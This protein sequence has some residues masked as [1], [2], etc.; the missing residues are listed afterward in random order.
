MI[1]FAPYRTLQHVF[2]DKKYWLSGFFVVIFFIASWGQSPFTNYTLLTEKDG[3]PSYQSNCVLEDMDGYLW[4]GLHHGLLRYDGR[5]F[6]KIGDAKSPRGQRI[7][8]LAVAD[9]L[10]VLVGTDVGVSKVNIRTFE[11]NH[12]YLPGA[13]E[14]SSRIN[15]V[16]QIQKS[17]HGNFWLVST[18]GVFLVSGALVVLQ[19]YYFPEELVYRA[20]HLQSSRIWEMA[21]GKVWVTAPSGK[22]DEFNTPG[23]IFE[24]D[25]SAKTMQ[26]IQPQ[27]FAAAQ[28]FVTLVHVNDTL[29]LF[30][31]KDSEG[32]KNGIFDLRTRTHRLIDIRPFVLENYIPFFSRIQL[33]K[34]G[35]STLKLSHYYVFDVTSCTWEYWPVQPQTLLTSVVRTQSGIYFSATPWGLMVTASEGNMFRVITPMETFL[36]HSKE[37]PV[38]SSGHVRSTHYEAV[39]CRGGRI[40]LHSHQDSVQVLRLPYPDRRFAD[41]N[42]R[43]VVYGAADTVL[44]GTRFGVQWWHPPSGATGHL[45]G[46]K[47][48]PSID[49]LTV[50]LFKDHIGDIW[51]G[52]THS[53]GLLRFDVKDRVFKH[54]PFNGKYGHIQL[55]EIEAFAEDKAG[56]LWMGSRYGGGLLKWVRGADSLIVHHPGRKPGANFRDYITGLVCDHSG[57]IWIGT[58]GYGVFVFHPDEMIFKQYTSADGLISDYVNTITIDCQGYVWI[59]ANG[60]SRLDA[61]TG[62]VKRF[63][64]IHGLPSLN[65]TKLQTD[66]QDSCVLFI[67]TDAGFRQI[68]VLELEEP[69]EDKQIIIN[70]ILVNGSHFSFIPGNSFR[71]TYDENNLEIEFSHLN[72]LDGRQDQYFYRMSNK[73]HWV[74]LGNS[75]EVHLTGLRSGNYNLYLKVCSSGG[76]CFEREMLSFSI[77]PPF[78]KTPWYYI[79]LCCFIFGGIVFYYRQRLS[80]LQGLIQLRRKISYDLHDDIGSNLGSIRILT[81]L[82]QNPQVSSEK[83]IEVADKIREITESAHRNLEE[84]IWELRPGNEQMERVKGRLLQIAT[85]VL[86]PHGIEVRFLAQEDID[87]L[88]LPSEKQRNLLLL[89]REA[90]NNIIKHAYCRQVWI[91]INCRN[92]MLHLEII[93]DGVGFDLDISTHKRGNGMDTL[94][95]RAQQLGGTLEIESE[96]GQGV[97]L[98]LQFAL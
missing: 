56:N 97:R 10:H 76:R 38:Y 83:K 12:L 85:E 25:P 31:F 11:E 69:D 87:D 40:V 14:L 9:S 55:R 19:S 4:V 32:T 47:K 61:K 46:A 16:Q 33:G 95:Y 78:W 96:P 20:I 52:P 88:I 51:L 3:I 86:E 65:I 41:Q 67:G 24:I 35:M 60:L 37:A 30:M 71:L 34:I 18:G 53:K 58:E 1:I 28:D 13:A 82:V 94:L 54:Y 72:L 22:G 91:K 79:I 21:D 27:I 77:R 89:Y 80:H 7:R 74:N 6:K 93:D 23:L 45:E 17:R 50:F 63:E 44:I 2:G 5:L 48:P 90:I 15:Y 43:S 92:G 66:H 59:G 62:E 84:I 73:D 75:N 36:Q 64:R 8:C 68:N 26:R 29:G 70:R 57:R 39:F 98:N 42:I 49:S 81:N